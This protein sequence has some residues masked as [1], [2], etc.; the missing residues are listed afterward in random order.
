MRSLLL[1]I[2]IAVPAAA[3]S[4]D[5]AKARTVAERLICSTPELSKADEAMAIAYRRAIATAAKLAIPERTSLKDNQVS[6]LKDRL[7]KCPDVSCLK[8]AYRYRIETLRFYARAAIRPPNRTAP[9][10]TYDNAHFQVRIMRL[11]NGNVKCEVQA[12]GSEHLMINTVQSVPEGG[13]G[14]VW[15]DFDGGCKVT[16][17]FAGREMTLT[18]EYDCTSYFGAGVSVG[19][20]YI[21]SNS[22]IPLFEY[23]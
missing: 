19:G 18:Q 17:R 13:D 6:W 8:S 12:S 15:N 11:G 20:S 1:T 9:T 5:C 21:L 7:G 3:A 22:S 16:F 4:F 14:M 23:P 10:G 2:L